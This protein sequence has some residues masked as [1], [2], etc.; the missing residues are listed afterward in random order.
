MTGPPPNGLVDVAVVG[1]ANID[2]TVRVPQRPSPGRTAFGTALITSPGGKSLNQAIAVAHLGGRVRLIAN[3]GTDPWGEQLHQALRDAGVDTTSFRL[4]PGAPT[5]AAIIEVTPDGEPYIVLALS[6]M[7]DL[8]DRDVID[9]L[10]RCPAGVVVS[11]LDLPPTA[12]QG[13]LHVP[14]PAVLIG[15]LI[16]HPELPPSVLTELDIL[17]VN[18]HEAAVVLGDASADPM[19]AATRL[20][21]LGPRAAVV[22][23]GEL[24]AAFSSPDGEG[25]VPAT[26]AKVV[27]ASGAGDAFLGALAV[28][29]AAG[30]TL[31]DA[32]AFAVRVGSKAV[33]HP[34]ALLPAHAAVRMTGPHAG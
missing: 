20:R 16:P 17:V 18:H 33:Q 5:G 34:G 31:P 3:A 9:A 11:Q 26:L 30:T 13:L 6:P 1:R 21:Q 4:V 27:D 23:A 15:N 12:I 2:L 10:T 24:G 25:V 7:T 28:R 8:S 19:Q 32:V 14:R 29:L 22:T